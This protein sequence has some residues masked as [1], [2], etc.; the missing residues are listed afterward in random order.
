MLQERFLYSALYF[1][2]LLNMKHIFM[3]ISPIYIVYLLK[4]YCWQSASIR[5]AFG[6]LMKLACVTIGITAV[7]FGPFYKDIPQVWNKT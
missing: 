5:N 3:Y 4:V 2:I 6:N 7:S 1:A